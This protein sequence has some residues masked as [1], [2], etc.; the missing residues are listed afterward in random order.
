MILLT[1][2]CSWTY[3][4]SLK[5]DLPHQLDQRLAT[6][7]PAKLGEKLGTEFVIQLAEGCGSNQRIVRT[8]L[9]WLMSQTRETCENTVAVIQWTDANRYEYYQPQDRD[10][11]SENYSDRWAKVKI[12][13]CLQTNEPQEVAFE[14]SQR[15]FE[16]STVQ[17][18]YYNNISH[19]SA[20]CQIF[21]NFGVP[22]VYFWSH[23]HV[24]DIETYR[25]PTNLVKYYK[26]SFPWID[27]AHLHNPMARW[28]YDIVA[29]NDRHPSDSGHAQIAE[30]IHA[31]IKDLVI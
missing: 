17:E 25:W 29:K 8:S 27:H 16:T 23:A 11:F 6:V 18:Q 20:L 28:H 9:Q 5:L 4:G 13:I 21:K 10:N 26:Q 30:I 15:R 24:I 14:R 22:Y 2:G 31:Q 1:N 7:W 12:D 3:G 19:F